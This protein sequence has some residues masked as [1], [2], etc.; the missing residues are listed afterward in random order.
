[1]HPRIRLELAKRWSEPHREHHDTDHL[2][3]VIRAV[4]LMASSGLAFD[5]DTV[6][7]AAWFH[8]AVYDVHRADNVERSATLA[9]RW[10]GPGSGDRI[11]QVVMATTDHVAADGDVEAAVLCDADLSILGADQQRYDEYAHAIRLENIHVPDAEYRRLRARVLTRYQ[12][13]MAL[14]ATAPAYELWE[15]KARANLARELTRLARPV[16]V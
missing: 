15:D 3:E 10:L 1:M 16:P 4:D 8:D 2:A 7:T 14:F 13:R 9:Q 11:A 12:S 5:M 6:H